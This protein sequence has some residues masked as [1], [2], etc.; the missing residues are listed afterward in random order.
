[1][2]RAATVVGIVLGII[3]L[4]VVGLMVALSLIPDDVYRTRITAAFK[5]ATG[6]DLTIG[7]DIGISIFPKF[8]VQAND[9]SLSNAPG[10]DDKPFASM[11]KLAVGVEIL[12]LLSGNIHIDE[13]LLIDPQIALQVAAD[14][15]NNWTFE[16]ATPATP[17]TPAEP[18]K[19]PGSA[20][21]APP[22]KGLSLGKV[23]LSNGLVT[24]DDKK[25]G[26]KFD[27]SEINIDV[28]LKSLS[29]PLDVDGSLVWRGNKVSLKVDAQSPSGLQT[30][31]GS[32][33]AV[34]LSSEL[35]EAQFDG[36]AAMQGTTRLWGKASLKTSSVR[37][38]VSWLVTPMSA[39]K[40]FG[41]FE[42]AGDLDVNGETTRFENATVRLDDTHGT[43]SVLVATG[44][45]R[46]Y[47]KATLAVDTL[48]ADLYSGG[49]APASSGGTS[50][51]GAAPA[52]APASAPAPAAPAA[53][54]WSEEKIDVSG[55]K[56]ADADLSLKA[57]TII[58]QNLTFTNSALNIAL[59]DGVLTA[60]LS[61]MSLYG[62]GG[63]AKVVLDGSAGEPALRT[64]LAFSGISIE[65]LL[66]DFAK[67]DRLTGKGN[68]NASITS[69]GASQRAIVQNLNGNGGLKLAN[70][71]IRG[72]NIAAMVRNLAG[73]FAGGAS[74]G[75]QQTDFAELGGT[76]TITNGVLHNDDLLMLNPLLRIQGQGTSNLVAR[77]VDYHIVP[78][79]VASLEGQ[80]GKSDL[81]GISVPVRVSGSWDNLSFA[82]DPKG[83]VE[84]ATKGLTNALENGQDPLKGALKGVLG[85]TPDKKT[86]GQGQQ[87]GTQPS[88]NDATQQILKGIFH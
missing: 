53:Q 57:K 40:G 10:F 60:T 69:H 62:G 87:Q 48:N 77:T 46:P 7:G 88:G 80:G 37:Q 82:P 47:I 50:G 59:K 56:A 61:D 76:F 84:G 71:A 6:R 2:R 73:A 29:D 52:S 23:A 36:R 35:L 15:R 1:M 72:I 18:D 26:K 55:L 79:A 31:E 22:V 34:K 14:G 19:A 81:T 30:A 28:T 20:G 68:L 24:Y 12:P 70:G 16:N 41:P 58:A 3:V 86:Q 63:T 51:S 83:L 54:G 78:K 39:G 5:Q 64:D 8:G 11:K 33:L 27:V 75:A 65:P 44:G 13:F 67:F 25:A 85:Q 21:G 32:P 17:A 45:E 42:L 74:G 66:K 49:P 4:L 38:L 9:V 43:G